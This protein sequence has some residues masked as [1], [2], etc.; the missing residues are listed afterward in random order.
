MSQVSSTQH[1][2]RRRALGMRTTETMLHKTE[3]ELLDRLKIR[4]GLSSRS[5]AVRLV[6]AKA[7]L[8]SFTPADAEVLKEGAR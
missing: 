7:D 6:L 1:R 2:V 5:D 8:D 3:I 4:L